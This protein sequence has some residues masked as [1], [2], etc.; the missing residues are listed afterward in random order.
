MVEVAIQGKSCNNQAHNILL[1]MLPYLV[2]VKFPLFY[3]SETVTSHSTHLRNTAGKMHYK[4]HYLK[5][6]DHCKLG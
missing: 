6:S 3:F 2:L 4:I 1:I 5:M